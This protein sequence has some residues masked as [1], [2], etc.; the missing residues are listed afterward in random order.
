MI[1][2]MAG[3]FLIGSLVYGLRMSMMRNKNHK[4]LREK[5]VRLG[6]TQRNQFE[7]WLLARA[8]KVRLST[9]RY[10]SSTDNNTSL[11]KIY[12]FIQQYWQADPSYIFEYR[13]FLDKLDPKLASEVIECIQ[14]RKTSPFLKFFSK[15]SDHIACGLEKKLQSVL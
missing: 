8:N 9:F 3:I 10:E 12:H 7:M 13:G 11:E 4:T 6:L 2:M 1:V 15:F 5:M 14:R